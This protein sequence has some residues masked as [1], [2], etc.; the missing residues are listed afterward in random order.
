MATILLPAHSLQLMCPFQRMMWPGER[1]N[2][3]QIVGDKQI[4]G[5]LQDQHDA[6]NSDNKQYSCGKATIFCSL[7]GL[8]FNSSTSR[9]QKEKLLSKVLVGPKRGANH[10][11]F[12][13]DLL[14]S[15]KR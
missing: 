12:A 15:I 3:M 14:R 2:G 11:K 1:L 9:N 6:K 13:K 7:P 4:F 10:S 5:E 8:L